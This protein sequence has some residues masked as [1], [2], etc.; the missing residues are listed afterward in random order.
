MKLSVKNWA[1]DK[2][3]LTTKPKFKNY[4]TENTYIYLISQFLMFCIYLK[5]STVFCKVLVM[6]D[7]DDIM[8]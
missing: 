1:K 4:N 5:M 7:D 8:L 2:P 6:N 3:N